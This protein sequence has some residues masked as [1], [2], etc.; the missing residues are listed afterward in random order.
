MDQLLEIFT[1]GGCHGNPG[2]GAWAYCIVDATGNVVRSH[3]GFDADTTNNRMELQAVI[4]ALRFV[5]EAEPGAQIRVITDSEY[6]K[7]GV[8]EWVH[9]WKRNGWKTAAKKAVKNRDLWQQLDAINAEVA[10]EWRWVR[11]HSG[12]EFNEM[13]DALVQEEIARN[14]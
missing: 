13:C 4:S 2:P 9:T 3:S 6:V 1:D 11:G 14:R 5:A 8:T 7:R 12:N 10:P